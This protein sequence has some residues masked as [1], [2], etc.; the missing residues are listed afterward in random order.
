MQ[1]PGGG[2]RERDLAGT[3]GHPA[4][5]QHHGHLLAVHRGV[6]V[7]LDR[8]AARLGAGDAQV[9][10]AGDVAVGRRG[11]GRGAGRGE[12]LAVHA[13]ERGELPG[14]PESRRVGDGVG[15]AGGERQRGQHAEHAGDR[16][17]DRRADR[18]RR[19]AAPRLER[20][21]RADDGG[22][23]QTR[24]SPGRDRRGPAGEGS[25]PGPQ[26]GPRDGRRR[27]KH[28]QH[29]R[30]PPGAED[31]PVRADPGTRFHEGGG[32]DRHPVG[33]DDRG[34]HAQGGAGG[35]GQARGERGGRR[36][37]PPGQPH[38]PQH[39]QLRHRGGGIPGHGLADEDQGGEQRRE[40]EREQAGRLVP[41]H[42]PDGVADPDVLVKHVDVGPPG[43]PG[44]VGAERRDRGL[45][46][47]QAG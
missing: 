31:Q 17:R 33:G 45:A 44:E 9:E 14:L 15:D 7:A 26:G 22:H 4:R 29:G 2:G 37:L 20:E 19:A 25:R 21:A 5:G 24:P 27:G 1:L 40:P 42:P 8:H 18:D 36:R 13:V 32:A 41:G 10:E 34:G 35:R 30:C 16:A 11:T 39:Q 3:G 43:H 38:R 12:V 6:G 23:R 47:L 46:A 28:E